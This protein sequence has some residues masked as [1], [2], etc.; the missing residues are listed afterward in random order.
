VD[1]ATVHVRGGRGGRGAATFRREP[2][3]PRGGPNGGDG[4]RGGS[5]LLVAT[6]QTSSLAA[7]ASRRVWNA[8]DGKPGQGGLKAGKAGTDLRLSVPVGTVVHDADTGAV[9]GDLDRDGAELVAA[10]G[11]A[12]GRGN[13]HFKSSIKQAPTFAE[14]GEV[15]EERGLRLELKLIADAGLVGA[16]NAG[17]SS[18]LRAIS[19]A[20]PRVGAYPFTTLDP[21]LGV[22]AVPGGEP[23]VVADIPGLI[24]GAA[25]GAGLGLRFLRHI[26]RT[27][28]LVYLIDGAAADPFGDLEAVRGEVRAYS[29]ELAHG[30]SILA[31]NKVDL[32]E[33]RDLRGRH[34][35][36]NLY[37]VSALTGE[38]VQELLAAV[39]RSIKEAPPPAASNTEPVTVHLR[40]QRPARQPP[41]VERRPWGFEVSGGALARL[42][43]RTDFD[44]PH[45]LANFQV[46]LDRMGVSEAL[47]EAGAQP[48]D[49]VRIGELEFEYR[50]G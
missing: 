42:V 9:R 7:Y 34:E 35:R 26:E 41:Q 27:R 25:R 32:A 24:E 29:A 31:V 49:T 47:E 8:G 22:A 3:E 43:T 33:V 38:G 6:H 14:P 36:D 10:A 19:A 44:S 15:G 18:L 1:S 40:P 23:L 11:G 46:Q 16:P 12:G 5:V 50:P 4:G 30:P 28:V 2:F 37:W 13:V 20:T 17:K 21:H 39:D 45:S 48:G